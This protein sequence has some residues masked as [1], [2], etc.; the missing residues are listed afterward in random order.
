MKPLATRRSESAFVD[1]KPPYTPNQAMVEANRCLYCHDAPCVKAC[2][3]GIDI[4]GFIRKIATGNVRGAARTIFDSNILGMS[5][6]RVCPVE[7]LC[8][9]DCVDN[10]MGVPP[11]QIGRLQ[12]YATDRAFQESWSFYQAGPDSGRSVGLIGGG[13]ASLACAHRLRRFGHAV[14]IYEARDRLGGLNTTG[15]APYKMPAE[16]SE[17][18][19]AW[20]LSI[21]G[22]EVRTGVQIPRDL[23]WEELL[24]RHDALFLGLG[25]GPDSRLGVPGEDLAGVEGAVA[26]IE[27][28][29]LGVVDLAGVERALVIGGGNTAID[30]ARELRGLGVPRVAMVYR[31]TEAGMSGY[32]HEWKAARQ[33]GV[34]G[35]FGL[36]PIAM[37]GEGR[38]RAVRCQRLDAQRRPI[39]GGDE[40]LPADLVLL[41]IGQGRLA[42]L[43]ADLPGVGVQQGRIVA[44]A[45]GA[46]GH[47]RVF[48]GGDCVN[49]GKEVVNAVAMGRDAAIAI[50]ALFSGLSRGASHG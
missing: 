22:V 36:Q 24:G 27:A 6:A 13:P 34:E 10:A 23:S 50:D 33:E 37:L 5:C 39:P 48:A 14:T 25:L 11:I 20:V 21:G 1:K 47:P 8:V 12:R 17:E 3:T 7:V 16:R 44:D 41:A 35:R 42:Q 45:S 46:T 4:P 28:M 38:V 19:V 31:G 43:V 40:E 49:G 9:G 26:W 30:A 15:V 2:P 18:E 32:A 29:K